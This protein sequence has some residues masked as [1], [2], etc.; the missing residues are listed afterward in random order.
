V[1]TQ[2]REHEQ[3]NV[4][5]LLEGRRAH[6][7]EQGPRN[8]RKWGEGAAE[9]VLGEDHHR[10]LLAPPAQAAV[11]TLAAEDKPG[12]SRRARAQES[13][14]ERLVAEYTWSCNGGS[15]A[16]DSVR[17]TLAADCKPSQRGG[18]R[19]SECDE[20][21]HAGCGCRSC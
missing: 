21:G 12:C 4:S 16:Q 2:R 18:P 11:L 13:V 15:R 20:R 5:H 14:T 7:E 17:G 10:Q 1:R 3:A 19:E 9:G 8:L 6:A